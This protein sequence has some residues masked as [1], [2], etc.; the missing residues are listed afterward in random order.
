MLIQAD[1]YVTI[2]WGSV[3]W[4]NDH[5]SCPAGAAFLSMKTGLASCFLV[6]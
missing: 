6:W 3:F 2:G 5:F 1:S 4:T